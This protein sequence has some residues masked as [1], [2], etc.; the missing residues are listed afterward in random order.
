MKHT[1]TH[2]YI[3]ILKF[4]IYIYIYL[5]IYHHSKYI[6]CLF[7]YPKTKTGPLK[8]RQTH[9][10]YFVTALLLFKQKVTWSFVTKSGPYSPADSISWI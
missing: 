8:G 10:P 2:I 9:S 4:Y 5:Y 1:H 6:Y 3:F 7:S